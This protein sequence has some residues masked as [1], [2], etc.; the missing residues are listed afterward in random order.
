MSD[1]SESALHA[2][3]AL[4]EHF[5]ELRKRLM[6]CVIS[7]F[8][9]FGICYYFSDHIYHF[10]VNPLAEVLQKKGAHQL[11]YTSL[12]EAFFMYVKLSF[13]AGFCLVFPIIAF[14]LW[15][16]VA[17]GLYKHEKKTFLPFLIASPILFFCGA[18]LAYYFIF[19]LAWDFFASFETKGGEGAL[20][21]QLEA[22][23]SEYLSLVMQLIFAF[24][25]CFQLP[26][27]LILLTKLGL[28]TS[29]ALSKNRKFVFLGCFIVGAILTPPD[30][31]SQ[32]GL[33]L[34]LY[35]LYEISILGACFVEKKRSS[36]KAAHDANV[37]FQI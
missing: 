25:I 8:V 33:A 3:H 15:R 34:P 31:I 30:V 7:L 1:G 5:I 27:V 26:V 17:P 10:L 14:Q 22:K 18:A 20:P 12:A 9:G 29:K 6:I 28:V 32:I 23:V 37:D 36:A 24:G 16:F 11:I 13:W 21:I 2:K 19:P 35:V 4:I